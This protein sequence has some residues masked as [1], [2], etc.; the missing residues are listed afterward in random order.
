MGEKV[1][2]GQEGSRESSMSSFPSL[3]QKGYVW[4]HLD[5]S[6]HEEGPQGWEERSQDQRMKGVLGMMDRGLKGRIHW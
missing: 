5:G 3:E 6:G 4:K 1:P 2:T